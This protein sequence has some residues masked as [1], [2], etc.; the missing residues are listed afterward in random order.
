M[1][2]S[3]NVACTMIPGPTST[4]AAA[5]NLPVALFNA[6]N[7]KAP[8]GLRGLGQGSRLGAAHPPLSAAARRGSARNFSESGPKDPDRG[9]TWTLTVT[10][11]LGPAESKR[12]LG[13][14]RDSGPPAQARKAQAGAE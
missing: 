11:P 13:E 9:P 2:G 4:A 5:A 7:L 1:S 14:N 10:A 8:R 6:V 12:G 3:A